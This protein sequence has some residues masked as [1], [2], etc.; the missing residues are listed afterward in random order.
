[1]MFC[2]SRNQLQEKTMNTILSKIAALLAWTI[3]AM[4]IY[5]GGQVLLGHVPDYTVIDWLPLYNFTLGVI[6]FLVTAVLI[7]KNHAYALPA[8]ITTLSF[9]ALI[10]IILLTAYRAVV[11]PDSLVAM[12]V[13]IVVWSII[14]TLLI[15]QTRRS[16]SAAA[17]A[18]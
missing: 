6:T 5:A 17:N 4:A 15:I 9:H 11:A 3:G 12:T 13:R 14:L 10:M 18:A 2:P 8:T 1:M 16:Q 7:W